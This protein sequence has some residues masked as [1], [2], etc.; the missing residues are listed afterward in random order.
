[1]KDTNQSKLISEFVS[2]TTPKFNEKLFIKSDDEI[3]EALK[4]VILS[5]QRNRTFTIQVVKFRVIDEYFEIQKTLRDYEEIALSK[6]NKNRSANKRKENPY[7]YI[8]LKDSD[9][10][11][12]VVTYFISI[13]GVSTYLDVYIAIPRI[14]DKFY[15]KLSGSV[16]S[17]MYQILEASTYNNTT[18]TN[19]KKDNVTLRTLFSNIIMTRDK[20]VLKTVDKE[21]VPCRFFIINAYRPILCMKYILGNY[22]LYGTL[23]MFNFNGLIFIEDE[24]YTPREGW[25]TFNRSNI[26]VSVPKE[27]YDADFVF[28]SMVYTIL[29]SVQRHTESKDMFSREFWLRSL[30]LKFNNDSVDKGLS[31]LESLEHVYDI[32]TREI[33]R[34]PDEMKQD[35]YHIAKWLMCEFANLRMKDNLDTSMKRVRFSEH[36]AAH[37]AKKLNGGLY[38]IADQGNRADIDSIRK[39]ISTRPMFLIEEIQK[40]KLVNYRDLV[41]DCDSFSA[42]KFTYKGIGGIGEKS[43][44]AIPDSFKAVNPSH[45][46]RIDLNT[47]SASDPGMTGIICPL[48]KMYDHG[49]FSDYQ[50]PNTWDRRFN[51]IKE[52]YMDEIGRNEV[53]LFQIEIEKEDNKKRRLFEVMK[54]GEIND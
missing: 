29:D 53:R 46:G 12:L 43:A 34:L 42:L 30:G 13:K 33:T 18:T 5:I 32:S 41:N 14:I 15:M 9:I 26:F 4:K 22:G 37:Y 6:K 52:K 3:I 31:V 48:A 40:D 23:D 17:P 38:R 16:Y 36:I 19:S 10:K 21:E 8:N 44:K 25:Y 47:S 20:G 7:D 51:D 50:E 49:F 54:R 35:I 24:D 11:L 2:K 1:M 27:I 39:A 28:Q 45:I